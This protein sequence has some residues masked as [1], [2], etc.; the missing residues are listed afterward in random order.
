MHP[1]C[2]LSPVATR[3]GVTHR[4]PARGC[5]RQV[6]ARSAV[7]WA[8]PREPR[9]P[10]VATRGRFRARPRVRRAP[11]ARA[12]KPSAG[13]GAQPLHNSAAETSFAAV[14]QVAADQAEKLRFGE[15]KTATSFYAGA[16][17]VHVNF[18]PLVV[19]LVGD[20]GCNVGA[21]QAAVGPLKAALEPMR[22]ALQEQ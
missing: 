11:L 5:V 9:P 18:F 8:A 6:S 12:V 2:V 20:A 22:E 17:L 21:M 15:L 10:P 1:A 16:A 13:P 3:G 19:T 4:G 7:G 14:L